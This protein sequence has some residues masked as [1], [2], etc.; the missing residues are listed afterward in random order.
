MSSP[1]QISLTRVRFLFLFICLFFSFF[2]K[3]QVPLPRGSVTQLHLRP[4]GMP[5]SCKAE[6]REYFFPVD[7][8]AAPAVSLI[9]TSYIAEAP[10]GSA[11]RPVIFIF[12]GGPGASSSPL[13][14]NAFGP[15]RIEQG[16]DSSRLVANRYSL[17]D[18]ADLVFMDPPGTGFTRVFDSARAFSYW[19]VQ[20]DARIFT[21]V[22][23][24]WKKNKGRENSPVFLC[25]ESYG[26]IRAAAIL[27]LS[28]SLKITGTILLASVF[29]FSIVAPAPG[30]DMPYLLFLPGMAAVA[31]YHHKLPARIQSPEQ[32]F[33]EA[34]EFARNEY[35]PALV[36][37]VDLTET[38]KKNM[39]IALSEWTGLPVDSLLKKNLRI[40]S[41][42]FQLML[43]AGEGKRVGQLN[44]Q[45]TGPLHNPGVKP[46][47]DDPSMSF[48]RSSR[49]L[50]G[51]YF[52]K[53]LGF[54]DTSAYRSLNLGVNSRWNFQSMGDEFGYWTIIPDLLKGLDL[55]PGM[56]LLVA[57]GYYDLATPVYAA[58]Y[59]LE[60]GGV[61]GERVEYINFPTGHSIFEK[62]E[63]LEKLSERVRE[64]IR[65]Q[66]RR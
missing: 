54:P 49:D 37:G 28:D 42:D 6:V 16:K 41:R 60:H 5:V 66:T 27:G 31:W 7:T 62:E 14:M 48:R 26:T 35:L 40:S 11:N 47:F 51:E 23:R 33:R 63:E 45:I 65:M 24:Q 64:F 43:L 9:T 56:K 1:S 30:N 32:A 53:E 4:G 59:V 2:S 57:G 18:Q 38:G 17:L 52:R 46:P 29:D 58:R 61:P 15:F 13:H 39:A 22:I 3:G 8:P 20:G 25:G 50:I 36:K 55:Q 34:A 10:A 44:G 21:S 19:D 12:N